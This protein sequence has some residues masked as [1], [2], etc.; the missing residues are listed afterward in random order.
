MH[1]LFRPLAIAPLSTAAGPDHLPQTLRLEL[2]ERHLADF[3]WDTAA[4]AGPVNYVDLA[5]LEFALARAARGERFESLR[6][7]RALDAARHLLCPDGGCYSFATG[8][9][10]R[11]HR[12]RPVQAQLAAL[13]TWSLAWAVLRRDADRCAAE[14][15][16]G[17]ARALLDRGVE[18]N[19]AGRA[20]TVP[21]LVEALAWQHEACWAPASRQAAM[22][23]GPTLARLLADTRLATLRDTPVPLRLLLALAR[24]FLQLHRITGAPGLLDNAG[25]AARLIL[26]CCMLPG[27]AYAA[28]SLGAEAAPIDEQISTARCLNLL[29]AYLPGLGGRRAA[30]HGMRYLAIPEIALSRSSNA[31]I[32]MLDQELSAPPADIPVS[33]ASAHGRQAQVLSRA[34]WYRHLRTAEAQAVP[35]TPAA[36]QLPA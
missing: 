21:A 3:D 4:P 2:F 6:A 12:Q 18:A 22:A 27:A 11:L 13:H 35:A 26:R 9:W 31:G 25:L 20:W 17:H 23:A 34:G 29:Q 24:A 30:C 28:D 1:N 33:G 5:G 19:D 8:N 10:Q 15:V 14:T 7:R 36:C 32:L 16:A